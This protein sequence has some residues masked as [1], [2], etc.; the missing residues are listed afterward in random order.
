MEAAI[1]LCG[2]VCGRIDSIKSAREIVEETMAGFREI[3]RGLAEQYVSESLLFVLSVLEGRAARRLD[4][5]CLL[6][7][8]GRYF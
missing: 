3:M 7:G 6:V 2:Q 4:G 5:T 1:P 8:D